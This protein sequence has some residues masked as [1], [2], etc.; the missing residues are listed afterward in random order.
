MSKGYTTQDIDDLYKIIRES[1][2]GMDM[3]IVGRAV[4]AILGQHFVKPETVYCINLQGNGQ[5]KIGPTKECFA[6]TNVCEAHP[7]A[8]CRKESL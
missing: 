8:A 2:P 6:G 1:A 5:C 3:V 7:L 4:G